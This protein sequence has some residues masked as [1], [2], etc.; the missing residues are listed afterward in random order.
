MMSHLSHTVG[1]VELYV[2]TLIHVMRVAA[3]GQ[4]VALIYKL[5]E[6]KRWCV[7]KGEEVIKITSHTNA[8]VKNG[9]SYSVDQ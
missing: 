1:C 9:K 3:A 5:A 7:R 8:E 2:F 6:I 4:S